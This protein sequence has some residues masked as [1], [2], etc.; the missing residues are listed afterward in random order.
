MSSL[1]QLQQ[2]GISFQIKVLSSLLKHKEFL[3]NINDILD[4]E[5]FDNPAHKWIVGEILRYYYK[6]HTTPSTDALQVEV[7]KIE[8]EVLKV[9]VVEQLKEALKS[10]NEDREYVEQEFS[11]FCKN[12]QIK[13]AILNSVSLLEKGQYDDIKYMMDQA[14][15]AGQDKSIG[16]EYE[17]DIETRYREEERAAIPT[18]WPHVN[19]LLMGGLGSGDLGIIFGNPGGGKSWM[20]VNIGAM[21]VQRGYTVCHYTLELS[22]YY[23]GKRY[24]ALF[25]GIDVQNVQ[26]HRGAIEEAVNKIKGK[27]IIKEF[28]MGKATTHSIESHIQKCRDLG[29]G[30]DLVIVD[31]VDLLKSKTKSI[32]PKDAIDDVY[33]A[34]KGMA[35]EL[36]VPIWTVSQVNRAG[37]KDDVI[38]GDKAAGS[39]NKM[40]I[41]DFAMSLSRKRQDK[42]NGTGRI[43]IM[44]NRYGMDG[45]TYAAKISTNNGNIE[46]N[47]DSL[48]DDELTFDSGTP[49]TGSN[50]PF[51]SGLDRD[52][53]AYL[54]NKFFELG[55]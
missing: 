37:A 15:K 17:K 46:I 13:K 21:A 18:A 11:S 5:M 31:Y 22:E 8:N 28:P 16:H 20:L 44:K 1:N 33:T 41:A 35:R 47:P 48:D 25:T 43:H 36:K 3:Q 10:S 32:D 27:L 4:T 2:Y 34:T 38:E 14:L 9:S 52:E 30:P 50:K 7:R 19:E 55:L 54:A 24:D 42:V 51:N 26:K 45:M 53:K 6:Y 29:Y 23:V 40:M 39:Y 12:Q 49:A